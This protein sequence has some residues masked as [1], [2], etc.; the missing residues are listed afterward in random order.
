MAGGGSCLPGRGSVSPTERDTAKLASLKSTMLLYSAVSVTVVVYAAVAG[1]LAAKRAAGSSDAL[2]YLLHS[3]RMRYRPHFSVR[4]PMTLDV[5]SSPSRRLSSITMDICIAGGLWP[6]KPSV[7]RSRDLMLFVAA[8]SYVPSAEALRVSPSCTPVAFAPPS[9]LPLSTV[10]RADALPLA[11]MCSREEAERTPTSRAS[12]D[13]AAPSRRQALQRAAGAA[14]AFGA[15]AAGPQRADALCG[16]KPLAWEF[17][18]P[19]DEQVVPVAGEGAAAGEG[20]RRVW[21]RL[22]GDGNA[23]KEKVTRL[24]GSKGRRSPV[25]VIP[26]VAQLKAHDYLS[27]LEA[28]VT[29]DRRAVS[30]SPVPYPSR[31]VSAG[32]AAALSLGLTSDPT[33]GYR[34]TRARRRV[35]V[36]HQGLCDRKLLL[37]RGLNAPRGSGTVRPPR[38]RRVGAARPRRARGARRVA[39]GGPCRPRPPPATLPR[40]RRSANA[41]HARFTRKCVN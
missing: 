8:V 31:T 5:V 40:C 33:R 38:L 39:G 16:S 7:P 3:S 29:S 2:S 10:R 23:E 34:C 13:T 19:W 20:G 1:Y 41:D 36:R 30:L 15:G 12:P 25:V 18:I 14:L 4:A 9:R 22:V 26:D 21:Y 11:E 32:L 6:T 35:P 28:I 17:W 24:D 37:L 27:T